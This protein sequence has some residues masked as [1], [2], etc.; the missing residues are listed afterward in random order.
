M[1]AEMVKSLA[2]DML[3]QNTSWSTY[4]RAKSA[5]DSKYPTRLYAPCGES[6]AIY[7]GCVTMDTE[8]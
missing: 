7:C 8:M 5:S 4:R 2:E 3:A 6:I 1:R